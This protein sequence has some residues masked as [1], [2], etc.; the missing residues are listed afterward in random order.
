MLVLTSDH[1]RSCD[2]SRLISDNQKAMS[3]G[4]VA[5]GLNGCF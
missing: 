3:R 4:Y 5:I 1:T 2:I